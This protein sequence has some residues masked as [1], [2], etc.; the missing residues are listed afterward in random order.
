MKINYW[1]CPHNAPEEYGEGADREWSYG[2]THPD[3]KE[4]YCFLDNKYGGKTADC[5]LVDEGDLGWEAKLRAWR[6][7]RHPQ[8]TTYY[9]TIT[10]NLGDKALKDF[11]CDIFWGPELFCDAVEDLVKHGAYPD[12]S[13]IFF[14]WDREGKD[15]AVFRI[16]DFRPEAR[17]FWAQ[18]V[19]P[20]LTKDGVTFYI[21]YG[22]TKITE[23]L[24]RPREVYR[25]ARWAT[26]PPMDELGIRDY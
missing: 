16:P 23:S 24:A 9:L 4:R 6:L 19:I 26:V 21:H 18:V 17:Q 22:D 25:L 7:R 13:D 8:Q 5:L 10:P 2:C 3:S 14:S 1:D 11:V 15:I 12:G 20:E